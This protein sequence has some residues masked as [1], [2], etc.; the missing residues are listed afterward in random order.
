MLAAGLLSPAG[1]M[2]AFEHGSVSIVACPDYEPAAAPLMHHH[3]DGHTK[4]VRQPCPF[5]S[6]SALGTVGEFGP[7]L[8][9]ALLLAAALLLGRPSCFLERH[10]LHE[11][12]PLRGPPATA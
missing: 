5:A 1:F 11:R 8:V 12:P 2:P 10:S 3:H 6:A 4:K 9:T 7:L